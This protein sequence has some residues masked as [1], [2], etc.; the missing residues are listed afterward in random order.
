MSVCAGVCAKHIF[1]IFPDRNHQHF[2]FQDD[3]PEP[4]DDVFSFAS[5]SGWGEVYF[6]WFK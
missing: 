3:T 2:F 6:S 5:V 4:D 1:L